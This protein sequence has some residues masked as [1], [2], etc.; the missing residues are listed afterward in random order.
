MTTYTSN[1][2]PPVS[3]GDPLKRQSS[4]GEESTK[5]AEDVLELLGDEY[6][7]AVVTALL[8]GPQTGPEILEQVDASRATVYRRLNAL[9]RVGVV[10][11]G[12]RLDPDGHHPKEFHLALDCLEV[13]FDADGVDVH[14]DDGGGSDPRVAVRGNPSA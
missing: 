13:S 2:R 10:E 12:L 4:Q 1:V 9:E 6:A 14:L 7:R 3:A 11:S 8:D 5:R